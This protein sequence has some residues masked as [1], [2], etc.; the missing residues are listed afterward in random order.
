M[1]VR[2]V[3]C[4]AWDGRSSPAIR[5]ARPTRRP[6]RFEPVRRLLNRRHRS[7]DRPR[8]LRLAA[9]EKP[10]QGLRHRLADGSSRLPA[11][12]PEP[13]VEV[14][15]DAEIQLGEHAPEG[16]LDSR[17]WS[18]TRNGADGQA[19]GI[20]GPAAL[21]RGL[22]W[23]R[24]GPGHAGD[25][26]ADVH[27]VESNSS[28][29]VPRGP[30]ASSPA[31]HDT[32]IDGLTLRTWHQTPPFRRIFTRTLPRRCSPSAVLDRGSGKRNRMTLCRQARSSP[33]R[34]CRSDMAMARTHFCRGSLPGQV[35]R[36]WPTPTAGSPPNDAT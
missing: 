35:G 6:Q 9:P 23:P 29:N 12:S 34:G 27:G 1:S 36:G 13:R 31:L 20:A 19:G 8:W 11:V 28:R 24:P 21:P 26:A 22:E 4:H 14:I 18:R 17:G 15:P 30:H 32:P 7:N 25:P 2:W 33:G 5:T 3:G 10:V 16:R